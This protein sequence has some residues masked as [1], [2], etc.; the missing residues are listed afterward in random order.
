M[1]DL[2]TIMGTVS[3]LHPGHPGQARY[4]TEFF[5]SNQASIQ[6]IQSSGGIIP[7]LSHQPLSLSPDP[8]NCLGFTQNFF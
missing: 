5:V 4:F 1:G 7:G 6:S 2:I 8:G 3:T